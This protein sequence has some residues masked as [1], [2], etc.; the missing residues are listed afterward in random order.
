MAARSNRPAG[1]K[2]KNISAWVW[3]LLVVLLIAGGGL[4][5]NVSQ[6]YRRVAEEAKQVRDAVQEAAR[7]DEMIVKTPARKEFSAAFLQMAFGDN[8]PLLEQ[9]KEALSHAVGSEQALA[10]GDIAMM[11]ITFRSEGELRDVAIHV[12]GNLVPAYLPRFSTD[13]YW[14]SSLNEQFFSLGQRGL[15]LLGREVLILANK[16]VEKRQREVIEAGIA[17]QYPIVENY[18]HDPVSFIAVLP[19]PGKLFTEEFRPY[20]AVVLIKGKISLDAFRFEMVALSY[21]PQKARNLAQMLSDLRMMGLGLG[22]LRTGGSG[23][24]MVGLDA[25][26]RAQ[27]QVDGPTV[28]ATTMLPKE[29]LDKGLPRLTHAV[30]KGIGRIKRGPGYPQ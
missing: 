20:I 8:P 5:L 27:I 9:I 1:R 21:D 23:T 6:R 28:T 3:T 29:F 13:G 24:S 14:R 7:R 10:H 19:D 16:E 26:K 12:F 4:A 18:L 2:G 22:R 30:S 25:L 11:L 15:S 17:G